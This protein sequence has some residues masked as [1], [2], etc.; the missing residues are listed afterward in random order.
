[1]WPDASVVVMTSPLVKDEEA[2]AEAEVVTGVEEAKFEEKEVVGA[3]DTAVDV[4]AVPNDARALEAV[5]A[6]ELD[7]AGTR[8]DPCEI[9][10]TGV[11]TPFEVDARAGF[12]T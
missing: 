8:V 11:A 7:G 5:S 2:A 6:L 4:D 12:D 10:G 1:M 3:R 9:G